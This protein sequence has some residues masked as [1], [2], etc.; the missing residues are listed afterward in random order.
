MYGHYFHSGPNDSD[1]DQV[2]DNFCF[3]HVWVFPPQSA[4]AQA[5]TL[6]PVGCEEL[7][8][9]IMQTECSIMDRKRRVTKMQDCVT[10]PSRQREWEVRLT[11]LP[12]GGGFWTSLFLVAGV[13][14]ASSSPVFW[15]SWLD[16]N[17]WNLN[18][19]WLKPGLGLLF[20][21]RLWAVAVVG[22]CEN[23]PEF[24]FVFL[25]GGLEM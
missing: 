12:A 24:S 19:A 3:L 25:K 8:L 20:W 21:L 23:C 2:G 16:P 7:A 5:R 14:H 11:A 10:W 13:C 22:W 9:L 1:S 4:Y 17:F 6:D 15:S 18:P